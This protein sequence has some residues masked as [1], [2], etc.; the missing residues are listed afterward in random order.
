[1]KLRRIQI[2]GFKS[3][4]DKVTIE[5]S[6][7]M[8]GIVGPNG[9]GKSN[10]VDALKWAMG[11]MS[12]KS[13]RGAALSDVIF[14]G[15]QNHRGAGMAE[16]TLTFEN[17]GEPGAL[18][19]PVAGPAPAQLQ[20]DGGAPVALD[21]LAGEQ[22][23]GEH[24]ADAHEADADI[25]DDAIPREYREMAEI[26]ITRRLYRSG[27]SEYL[28]NKTP[29]RL[30][31]IRNLLAGTGL[32]K[33]G[34]SVIEQGEIA[35]VVS[36]KPSERRLIIEE[37]SG[38]TRY[39]SQRDR[40]QRKLER[41]QENLQRIDDVVAEVQKQ[42][43]SLER[44]AQRAERFK[45]LS[46]QLRVL[47][48]S[49]IVG[50]RDLLSEK[51]AG[52][53]KSLES[54]RSGTEKARETL[55][56]LEADLST[57]KIEAFVAERSSAEST[58]HFYKL[59]TRLNLAKSNREHLQGALA[60]ARTRQ[61]RALDEH[62]DQLRRRASLQAELE[63]VRA[64]L[65]GLDEGPED[66]NLRLER[67]EAERVSLQQSLSQA[68][69]QRDD[70]RARLEQTRAEIRRVHDRRE[71]L[72]GQRDEIGQRRARIDDEIAAAERDLEDFRRALNRLRMDFERTHDQRAEAQQ[73]LERAQA[74]LKADRDSLAFVRQ[75]VEEYR[76]ERIEVSARVQ[77]LGE[78]RR[79][80]DGYTR[81]VQ[82][83]LEWARGQADAEEPSADGSGGQGAILGPVG[84]LLE[85]PEGHEAAVSAYLGEV[86]NDI[87]ATDRGAAMAAVQML[88]REKVGRAGFY[89][90][91]QPGQEPR[92]ELR[93]MLQELEVVDDLDDVE[94]GGAGHTRAWATRQGDIEFAN[95]RIVG[96][97]HGDQAQSLLR[98]ARELKELQQRLAQVEDWEADAQEEFDALQDKVKHGED[99]ATAARK[100][101]EAF[102]LEQRRIEQEVVGEE[103]ELERAE[104]RLQRIRAEVEP[105]QQRLKKIEDEAG[106]LGDS[107]TQFVQQIPQLEADLKGHESDC[108]T[109]RAQL[110][111]VQARAT[112][113]KIALAQASE[114]RRSLSESVQRLERA[115]D[116]NQKQLLKLDQEAREQQARL[117]EFEDN[118]THNASELAELEG[119]FA[120]AK[121]AAEDASAHLE[122]VQNEVRRLE[123]AILTCRNDVEKQGASLQQIEMSLREVAIEIEHLDRN[124]LERFEMG[125]HEAAQIAAAAHERVP[126]AAEMD[127]AQRDRRIRTL[128]Q[129]IEKMG[130]VNAMAVHEFEEAREREAFL[131]DQQLDLQA[132]IDDLNRAIRR[133]D[134][135]SRKRF[136]QTFEAV[137]QRFQEFFPRLFRGG[138]ARLMLTDPDNVLESG[139]D[140]EVC[141]PG[142]RLQNVTLLSG[143]EKALTAVSL[144]FAIFSLKPTPFSV[145]DEV[146]APLD[147]ANVGRYAEMVRE[148]SAKSQMIVITHNRRS[149]EVCDAL[150]GVTMEEPGVSKVV[151]V[152]L[153]DIGRA[154]TIDE[155]RA[156]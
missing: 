146:D 144:I 133:M 9:C 104:K 148:L 117:R 1:M 42:L 64:E 78:M 63:R 106:A 119:A 50:R 97:H 151:S 74:T 66:T 11:D 33:Q 99:R 46:E 87:V 147:E 145:L 40:S 82:R 36:A 114:R 77:T 60:E 124:L 127:A 111:D 39:K 149:M 51:A 22:S 81:G 28:I 152:R 45:Q 86:F 31:D 118:S 101:L 54:G 69:Q 70:A 125:L 123:L 49:A 130:A 92:A 105:L 10:V 112:E 95:G 132:A 128:R 115:L 47:E 83:V 80:G 4:K 65:A 113:Y 16:V 140:I 75:E 110:D 84:S 121:Q 48:I 153:D 150:Y 21:N 5:L 137:N 32:G 12:A 93:A 103:R 27:E 98:Q 24:E 8:N 90:L 44:Q 56:K 38:I 6:D 107:S 23:A 67:I 73:S 155:P 34:Y 116:S 142:K 131:A 96:G 26:A 55:K 139:V 154:G 15:S 143:G 135:E 30:M 141:P 61:A 13:L 71:W 136:R 25:W 37:A 58:E 3:F 91:Q 76:A 79:R 41:A 53:R 57:Q 62:A 14:A 19:S 134:R 85:V 138:Y 43:R 72:V 68:E 94:R 52:F 88:A 17:D 122:R 89:I 102:E 20:N 2:V 109:L 35:F 100:A 120:Q 29:C 7:D 18:D 108:D 126:E 156:S 59:D 129:E